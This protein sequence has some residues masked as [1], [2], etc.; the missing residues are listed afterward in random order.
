VSAKRPPVFLLWGEDGF[1][2]REAALE[3][4]AGAQ[5]AEVEA[6]QWRGGE[7]ADLATPSIF[8]EERALLVTDCRG[9]S[10]AAVKEIS[11]HLADPSPDAMLILSAEVP[12]RGSAP[13]ALAKLVRGSGGEVRQVAV[14]RKDLPAWVLDRARRH[15]SDIAPDAARALVDTIGDQPASLD[16][17]VQQLLVAYPGRR[18]DRPTVLEQFRGLGEQRVWDLCD[19]AFGRDLSGSVRA[20]RSLL[21]AREDPL[22]ILG[23]VASRLRDLVRV[24]ALPERMP[25]GE[26]AK[27]AGL[28]FEWQGRRYREQAKRFE[29]GELL[30]LHA[31][32]VEA[33]RELKSGGSG[34]VVLPVVVAAVA[35]GRNG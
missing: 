10:P 2:L 34:D 17:A 16:A 6:R 21:E 28:R 13:A 12:E 30:G 7:V 5:P 27:A 29:M 19:R 9:L 14:A 25:A 24:K 1:L 3:L 11:S 35:A 31:R 8:G 26:M 18:I 20:L 4:L 33:D 32:I 23:S 22:V 15:G